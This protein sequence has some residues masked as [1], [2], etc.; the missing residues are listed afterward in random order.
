MLVFS[1]DPRNLGKYLLRWKKESGETI[2]V[3]EFYQIY[4]VYDV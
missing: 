2:K 4:G 3:Q 1:G